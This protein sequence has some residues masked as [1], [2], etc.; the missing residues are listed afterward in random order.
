MIHLG[1]EFGSSPARRAGD[2]GSCPGPDEKFSL[3]L[4]IQIWLI[5]EMCMSQQ[6]I[7]FPRQ[8]YDPDT[9]LISFAV[10]S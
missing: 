10:V 5:W 1:G 3:K 9:V 7:V 8:P 4:T 6:G 2:P